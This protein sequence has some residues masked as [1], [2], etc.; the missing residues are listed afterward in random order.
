MELL[1]RYSPN[2][3]WNTLE[4][5]LS[6]FRL[7]PFGILILCRGERSESSGILCE[8]YIEY[9][10]RHQKLIECLV[11]KTS[12]VCGCVFYLWSTIT[13]FTTCLAHRFGT[14]AFAVSYF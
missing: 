8:V 9:Q 7:V 4:E 13:L 11:S 3:L 12:G 1:G 5:E 2:L 14:V 6:G 10:R